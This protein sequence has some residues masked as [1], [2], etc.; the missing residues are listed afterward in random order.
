MATERNFEVISNKCNKVSIC[1]SGNYAQKCIINVILDPTMSLFTL[2]K[3]HLVM[4]KSNVL[5]IYE[6]EIILER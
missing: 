1:I 3:Q 6:T 2:Y 4:S 5:L